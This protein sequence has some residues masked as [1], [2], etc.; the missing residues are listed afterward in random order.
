MRQRNRKNRELRLEC[1]E[2]RALMAADVSA[3][4]VNGVLNIQGTEGADN[5]KVWTFQGRTLA[6]RIHGLGVKSIF[7][8]PSSEVR[9]IVVDLKGGQDRVDIDMRS[10]RV[11]AI[12]VEMGT[13]IPGTRELASVHGRN[14]G[15]V[16][17]KAEKSLGAKVVFSRLT[18][19]GAEAFFGTVDA[20]DILEVGQSSIRTLKAEMRGGNDKFDVSNSSIGRAEVNLGSGNDYFEIETTYSQIASGFVDGGSGSDDFVKKGSRG[21]GGVQVLNFEPR[22]R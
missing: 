21:L 2:N 19:T 4:L 6:S 5:V 10:T 16:T 8:R 18:A 7:D 13:G 9:S 11:N 12:M 22:R 17:V 20:S 3:S 14:L 15:Q 1:L